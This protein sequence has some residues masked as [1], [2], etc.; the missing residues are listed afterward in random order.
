MRWKLDYQVAHLRSPHEPHGRWA[1]QEE[2]LRALLRHW[3]LGGQ[4]DPSQSR[5][6][7]PEK[8]TAAPDPR[9]LSTDS[10]TQARS[11]PGRRPGRVCTQVSTSLCTQ[12][13]VRCQYSHCRKHAV[14]S[15]H[16]QCR[17]DWKVKVFIVQ[18]Y[19]PPG[20]SVH[21]ILQVR[22]LE[23]VAIPSSRGSPDPEIE[24]RSP[25]LHVDSL[26]SE[27]PGKPLDKTERSKSTMQTELGQV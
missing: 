3:P 7:Y 24:P 20:S 12:N 14:L 6:H 2:R 21:W 18:T 25:A 5:A 10:Q 15:K 11:F 26:P 4:W 1:W 9:P 17:Q 23:S 22:I 8:P 19:S 13:M 16:N 27:P